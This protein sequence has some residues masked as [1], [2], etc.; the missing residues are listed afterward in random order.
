LGFLFSGA[1]MPFAST[2]DL[3]INNFTILFN[4]L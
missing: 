1:V 2:L 3:S 4:M